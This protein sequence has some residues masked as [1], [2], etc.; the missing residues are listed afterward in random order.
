M[1]ERMEKLLDQLKTVVTSGFPVA[2]QQYKD[3]VTKWGTWYLEAFSSFVF[4]NS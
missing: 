2:Q 1:N 3:E 4:L